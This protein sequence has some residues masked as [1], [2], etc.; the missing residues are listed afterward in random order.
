MMS[1]AEKLITIAVTSEE[2][3]LLETMRSAKECTHT[4]DAAKEYEQLSKST[5]ALCCALKDYNLAQRDCRLASARAV[6]DDVAEV[7]DWHDDGTSIYYM[8]YDDRSA[9][10]RKIAEWADRSGEKVKLKRRVQ[11]L[12]REN[13]ILRSVL[14]G[15]K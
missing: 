7:I 13:A 8:D 15:D 12:E 14:G 1:S 10:G 4:R 5:L 9:L 3:E 6:I 11:E 2:R